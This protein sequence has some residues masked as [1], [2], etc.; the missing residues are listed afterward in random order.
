MK[1]LLLIVALSLCSCTIKHVP[2]V[3]LEDKYRPHV[4]RYYYDNQFTILPERVVYVIVE[5][6]DTTVVF[7]DTPKK[8]QTAVV[9]PS[10]KMTFDE[11]DQIV[12]R[13]LDYVLKDIR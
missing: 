9:L 8:F 10:R 2:V 7:P 5:D 6:V 3:C 1:L 11:R 4:L 12:R 13:A